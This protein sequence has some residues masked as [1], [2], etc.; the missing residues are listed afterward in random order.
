MGLWSSVGGEITVVVRSEDSV[1][2][3]LNPGGGTNGGAPTFKGFPCPS[4]PNGGGVHGVGRDLRATRS[5]IVG[6]P[7]GD[8]RRRSS[9]RLLA[10]G[11]IPTAFPQR[12]SS[13][14]E[15]LE[16]LIKRSVHHLLR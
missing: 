6:L 10:R 13:E 11:R 12:V 2:G 16:N 4:P 9:C 14:T 8:L 5:S 15:R 7:D 3:V 1:G